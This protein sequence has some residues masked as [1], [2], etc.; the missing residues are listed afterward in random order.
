MSKSIL[1]KKIPSIAGLGVIIIGIAFTTFLVK[2]PTPFQIQADPK[3]EPINIQITNVSDTAF[4]VAYTTDDIVIG[5]ISFGTDPEKL[6]QIALDE[7]DQLSQKVNEYQAHSLTTNNL[8]PNTTYYFTIKS[9][10][11]KIDNNGKP[12]MVK[13][14]SVISSSPTTQIP[15]AGIVVGP[16]GK[17]AS[18]GLILVTI[19]GAQKISGLI[20]NNGNYSIPLNNLRTSDLSSYYL[21]DDSSVIKIE[22]ISNN[23]LSNVNI[24]SNQLSPVPFI[25]LSKNYN[26][27]D[28]NTIKRNIKKPED[29]KFPEFDSKLKESTPTPVKPKSI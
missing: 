13:T 29:V 8:T 2:G 9:G 6:D 17:P 27:S 19:N 1:D 5:T 4:T 24:T 16:K 23:L 18:D 14:G 22:A 10:T 15:M 7:R 12:F 25:T 20:K 3:G 26:F 21:L 11:K 28:S